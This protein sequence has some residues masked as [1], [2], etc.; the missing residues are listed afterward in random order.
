MTIED[1]LR[2]ILYAA[3]AIIVFGLYPKLWRIARAERRRALAE[4]ATRKER[5]DG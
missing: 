1:A 2:A 3:C 4:A 5:S